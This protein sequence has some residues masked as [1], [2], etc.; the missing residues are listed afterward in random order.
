[1]PAKA[2]MGMAFV[3]VQHL[4]PDHKSLLSALIRRC[5][6]MPVLEVEDGMVVQANCVYVIP[7]NVDMD[8][9][10]G[11]LHLQS[12]LAPHGQRLPIDHFFASLAQELGERAI[13]IVLSGMGADGT[14]GV[15]A[16]KDAGGMVMAQSDAPSESEGMP[17]SAIATGLVDYQLPPVKMAAQLLA[18]VAHEA[19]AQPLGAGSSAAQSAS[20]L[21]KAF[22]LLRTQTGHDFSQYKPSTIYR[23][24]ER[25]MA[26]HQ[27]DSMETYVK[28]LEQTPAEVQALLQDFLIGVTNFFRDPAA[29]EF[30]ETQV[31][32]GLFKGKPVG[33]TV[34]VWCTGCSTGEEAYSIAILL[35][36]RMEALK[37]NYLLQVFA[38]D[39]DARAITAARA[40]TYPASIAAD[41]SAQRL[42]RF[43]TLEPGGKSYRIHKSIRDVLVFSEQDLIKD[44]SFSKLDLISCRN[45]LIY[46]TADLQKR[47][48]PLFH[49][50]LLP[51]GHL[52][53]GS[54]EGIGEFDS[55]FTVL[56]RKAKIYQRK[57]DLQGVQRAALSRAIAPVLAPT[58]ARVLHSAAHPKQPGKQ[59]LRELMEQALL[60]Q[61][62]PACV[63]VN[64]G[65][66][67]VY[68]HGHTGLYLEASQGEAGIQNILKMARPGLRPALS[69]A[70]HQ[71]TQSR[72][73]TRAAKLRVKTS[74]QDSYVNLTVQQVASNANEA[75]DAALYLVTLEDT[76]APEPAPSAPGATL[77]AP[78]GSAYAAPDAQARIQALTQELRDKD[79]YL[80]STH[81][82][83]ESSNE[84]LKS[85]VEEMQSV[86][87][88]LQS[89]NEE[90]ETSKE[91]LQS[92]NEEL[93]TVNSELHTKVTDLSRANN[94]MNNLLAGTGVGT[95]FVDQQL[96]ILRF[97]PA[98]SAIINLIPSDLG[99]SVG[100]IVS[101]L[102]GYSS[103]VDD[104]QMV[105]R[106]LEPKALEVQTSGKAWYTLHIQPYR[107]LD[108]VVEGAVI[109]FEDIT[110]IVRTRG[111][112]EKAN[113]LLRLAVVVRDSHDAITVQDLDG[114]TLAWNPGAVRLYGWSEAQALQ[115]N[116]R[117]R[118]PADLR[119]GALATLA[120]LSRAEVLQPYKTQ[121]LTSGGQVVD[122][123]IISTALMDAHGTMYGIATTERAKAPLA[124]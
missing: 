117:D 84:E 96:K 26:V 91:E 111:A 9:S 61:V 52:F 108:N 28:F 48:I 79:E 116:V 31:L 124:V 23:R 90:L 74:G 66:D 56:D 63:V 76:P 87:E 112:L 15:R 34:R 6:R 67:I 59:P 92:V 68:V 45:L 3:L 113:D 110:D 18:D 122:V 41:M 109:S 115:M 32:P 105:L 40:G 114:Q 83:L 70:L 120:S 62:T 69:T 11:V 93:A 104:V 35:V 25:R 20:A 19:G 22:A 77:G 17:H 30:L 5:T 44:P 8:L 33:A 12:P 49:Y 99:R 39:I 42:A 101:N 60:R 37:Q 58:K 103:L 97:T 55:L 94:D 121:R 50:A 65:G 53:L 38:T 107:T 14:L 75:A 2:D 123:S 118:I 95:V 27:T 43:F 78:P 21:R 51:G 82:Q 85:S 4:A 73:T 86:N 54:S 100:H 57:E 102:V 98:A 46:L 1:M 47:L 24:I 10:N 16:I 119:E 71:A 106:S 89:T 81:E 80:Q 29:F 72:Q 64:A 36:E 7:P 13:G 88:E